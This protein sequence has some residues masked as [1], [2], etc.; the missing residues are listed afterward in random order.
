[1]DKHMEPL[2]TGITESNYDATS[3]KVEKTIEVDNILNSTNSIPVLLSND[4]PNTLSVNKWEVDEI[5][6]DCYFKSTIQIEENQ[7]LAVLKD[8]YA[9]SVSTSKPITVAVNKWE[10]DEIDND[11]YFKSSIQIE[12]NQDLAVVKDEYVDTLS[13]RKV[14]YRQ[15]H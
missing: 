9:D 5:D 3:I 6:N 4:K 2:S 1:M 8:E 7:D 15:W 13:T 11:C 10:V 14:V 12:E